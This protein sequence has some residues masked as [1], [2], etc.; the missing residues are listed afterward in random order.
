MP[1]LEIVDDI[2][3]QHRNGLRTEREH[4]VDDMIRPNLVGRVQVAG[5]GCRLEGPHNDARRIGAQMK[6]LPIQERSW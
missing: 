4:P 6:P 1:P 5:F 2:R 3:K